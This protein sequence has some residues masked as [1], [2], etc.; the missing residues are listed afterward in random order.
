MQEMAQTVYLSSNW[1]VEFELSKMGYCYPRLSLTFIPSSNPQPVNRACWL[2][3]FIP[4]L[5][6]MV[7]FSLP[8]LPLEMEILRAPTWFLKSIRSLLPTLI[9]QT[10][11]VVISFLG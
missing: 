9:R 5:I 7:N 11:R 1:Q 6:R 8:I 3:R 10:P 2:S 4:H